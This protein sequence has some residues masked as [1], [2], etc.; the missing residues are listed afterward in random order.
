[1]WREAPQREDEAGVRR[2]RERVPGGG[3]DL[4]RQAP[5]AVSP[6]RGQGRSGPPHQRA[7]HL[8]A[9]RG[10]GA[11]RPQQGQRRSDPE[12]A[13][14]GRLRRER[15]SIGREGAPEQ[16]RVTSGRSYELTPGG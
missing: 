15:R 3:S 9:R 10:G 5:V 13:E 16:G 8:L 11:R 12:P 6:E 4:Q 14:Q 1:R 7:Q 2:G